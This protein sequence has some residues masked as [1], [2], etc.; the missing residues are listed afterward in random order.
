MKK[1]YKAAIIAAERIK[2][3]GCLSRDMLYA[4]EEIFSGAGL[5]IPKID[6]PFNRMD[7]VI[8][9]LRYHVENAKYPLLKY[10]GYLPVYSRLNRCFSLHDNYEENLKIIFSGLT[11]QGQ[12]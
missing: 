2:E 9:I 5:R 12:I 6:H 3:D 11:K 7:R 1:H 4:V 8:N 10:D